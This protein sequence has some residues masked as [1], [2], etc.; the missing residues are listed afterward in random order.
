MANTSNSGFRLVKN[1]GGGGKAQPISYPVAS[2]FQAV[3]NGINVDLCVGDPC[4]RLSTGY[5][6]VSTSGSTFTAGER[7]F[8]I[9]VGIE[10]YWD[11]TNGFI[12]MEG[13]RVPGGTT[14]GTVYERETRVLVQP[15]GE[16]TILE[17]EF[18]TAATYTTY[19]TW[20]AKIGE[21]VD[22]LFTGASA[23]TKRANPRLDES[24]I[25]APGTTL[26]WRIVD[27]PKFGTQGDIEQDWTSAYVK[28]WVTPNL[29]QRAPVYTTGT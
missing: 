19:A 16:D 6:G 17:I 21:N 2:G 1:P 24:T 11:S 25:A 14:Y 15:I 23:T 12:S 9:I 13:N 3:A 27:I 28:A 4:F 29:T 7:P 20:L 22:L 8:G 10:Q 18:S 26:A 5:I